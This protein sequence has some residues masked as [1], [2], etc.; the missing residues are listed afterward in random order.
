MQFLANENIPINTT[1]LLRKK[2]LDIIAIG[3]DD[4]SVKDQVVMELA[5]NMNRTI[6]TFDRDYGELIF[7]QQ[8]RPTN[9]VI[10]L[11]IP[12]YTPNSLAELIFSLVSN[13]NISFKN[14]L[15]VVDVN[16]IRQRQY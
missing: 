8:Y 11:R 7:K 12:E 5:I 16:G 13:A 6:I 15:T 2:G 3:E 10:Y 9:G 14:A 4:P 1:Y